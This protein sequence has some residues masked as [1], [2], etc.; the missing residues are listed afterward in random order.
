MSCRIQIRSIRAFKRRRVSILPAH[1][2][3][4]L[5]SNQSLKL[6][7]NIR[8]LKHQSS[9]R[10]RSHGFTSDL[11]HLSRLYSDMWQPR[12]SRPPV[13]EISFVSM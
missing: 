11:L 9:G 6:F 3:I 5:L 2:S 4:E 10:N 1:V 12:G 13:E 8:R 7:C